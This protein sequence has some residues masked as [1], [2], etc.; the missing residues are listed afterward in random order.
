V[1]T[2]T[3]FVLRVCPIWI[4]HM[5]EVLSAIQKLPAV[6]WRAKRPIDM[7]LISPDLRL[8][9]QPKLHTKLVTFFAA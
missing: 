7:S 8:F 2:V 6:L 5:L 3:Q 4:A 1:L 9:I